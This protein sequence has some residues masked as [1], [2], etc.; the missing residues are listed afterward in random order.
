MSQTIQ[1][2]IQNPI[3]TDCFDVT[4]ADSVLPT[5]A[6]GFYVGVAG[7]VKVTTIAGTAVSFVGLQ[8]GVFVPVA[9]K[10]IWATGTTAT[11]IIGLV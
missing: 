7:T 11:N 3:V 1:G 8:A 4:P 9:V 2:V 6:I 10:Q 5:A